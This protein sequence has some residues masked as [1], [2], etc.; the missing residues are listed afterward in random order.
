MAGASSY[1]L[2]SPAGSSINEFIDP[3]HYSLHYCSVDSGAAI[4]NS[5]G[6]RALIGKLDLKSAF[7]LLPVRMSD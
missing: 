3:Q 1:D 7:R 2:S 6:P 4:L 5:L